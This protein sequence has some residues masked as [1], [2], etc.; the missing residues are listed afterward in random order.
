MSYSAKIKTENGLTEDSYC[1]YRFGQCGN[2]HTQWKTLE[3]SLFLEGTNP[4]W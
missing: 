3:S 1:N 2:P 4:I